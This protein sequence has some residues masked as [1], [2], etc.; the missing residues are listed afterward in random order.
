LRLLGGV[1]LGLMLAD[2]APHNQPDVRGSRISERHRR[3]GIRFQRERRLWDAV[4]RGGASMN[5]SNSSSA[6]A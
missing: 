5:L 1:G 6:K 4:A 2:L 3:P